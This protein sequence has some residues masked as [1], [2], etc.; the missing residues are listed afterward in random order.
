[1]MQLPFSC[2]PWLLLAVCAALPLAAVQADVPVLQ[3][4][5]SLSP[6]PAGEKSAKHSLG[7]LIPKA[8]VTDPSSSPASPAELP[9]A[10]MLDSN[11]PTATPPEASAG[12]SEVL[13]RVFSTHPQV[14]RALGEVEASRFAIESARAGYYPYAQVQSAV[15]DKS[16]QGN[17][18]ISLVQPLWDGGL[19]SAQLEEAKQRRE[20]AFASLTQI[21]MDLSQEVIVAMFDVLGA[22]SQL[23]LWDQ[24]IAQLQ[25]S[26]S[27]IERRAQNGVAPEADVQTVLVRI[28]LAEAGRETARTLRIA[29]R[30]RLSSLM[31]QPPPSLKW[32][33]ETARLKAE[34]L[35]GLL[36]RVEYH[37]SMT[38]DRQAIDIQKA[39]AEGSKA[40]LWPQLSLQHRQQLSGSRFDPSND[41]TLFVL[42]YQTTNGVRGYQQGRVEQARVGSAEQKLAATRAA[43]QAQFR[44]DT[45]QLLAFATQVASQGR[46]ATAASNL[47]DSYQRQFEA[48]RKTWLELLN[49][50]REAHDSRLQAANTERAYWQT[51]SR[52]VLQAMLWDRLGLEEYL[53]PLQSANE[54]ER[55]ADQSFWDRLR[56]GNKTVPVTSAVV[57]PSASNA[58]ASAAPVP[59]EAKPDLNPPPDVTTSP[60]IAPETP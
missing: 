40:S 56:P 45:A 34:D 57:E 8:A 51:N 18:T 46:A 15:A 11:S 1:M 26:R 12:L 28:S 36:D 29:A 37:P 22:E 7:S 44:S 19:T 13:E 42:Q 6:P 41:A 38:V 2:R 39:V 54:V 33:D 9:A 47:V 53:D 16:D 58:M 27:T 60:S 10:T 49:A 3:L 50:I 30:S 20:A 43:L 24:Y 52:L 14:Q 21:R 59:P 32:P 48:G 4:E 25:K 35:P 5:T 31:S 23:A 55:T 17:T